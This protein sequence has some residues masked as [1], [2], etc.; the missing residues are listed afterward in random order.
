VA[1]A[2]ILYVNE[3]DTSRLGLQIE[4][5]QGWPDGVAMNVRTTPVAGRLGGL[6]LP[7]EPDGAPRTLSIRGVIRCASLA[8]LL[9]NRDLL[10]DRLSNGTLEVRFIDRPDRVAFARL[11]EF[12]SPRIGPQFANKGAFA[13]IEFLCADPLV[14]AV[15]A[16]PIAFDTDR[17][18]VPLG[19]AVVAPVIRIMGAATNPVITYRNHAGL[20]VQ[21]MGFTIT[22]AATDF[23]EI[24]CELATVTK[25]VSGVVTSVNSVLS[26][27]DFLRFDPTHGNYASSVWPTIET[28]GGTGEAIYRRAWR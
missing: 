12:R 16:P 24:D 6:I 27:G 22:L 7:P 18:A 15:N 9:T 5:V 17:A 11:R 2:T 19:T 3:F 13:E 21:T 10:K 26:S 20:A 1:T 25:S 8:E 4:E 28:N 14:Y 23:L